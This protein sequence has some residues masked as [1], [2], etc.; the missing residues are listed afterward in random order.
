[1]LNKTLLIFF[2]A[3]L[4]AGQSLFKLGNQAYFDFDFFDTVPYSE[5]ALLDTTKKRLTKN[6]FLEKELVYFEATSLGHQHFGDNHIKLTERK[7]QLLINYSYERLVAYP[8]IKEK[9]LLWAEKNILKNILPTIFFWAIKGVVCRVIFLQ[10]KRRLLLLPLK[11]KKT[12]LLLLRPPP[13][14]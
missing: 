12:F 9:D 5:W 8:L 4:F 3:G 14:L 13:T 10:Q 7:N 1:M 6:S 11:L 2:F